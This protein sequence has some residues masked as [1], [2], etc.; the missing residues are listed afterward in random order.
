MNRCDWEDIS[1]LLH[2]NERQR[3]A[4]ET[5][6]RLDVFEMLDR[7]TPT[8]VGTVPIDIDVPES[9]LDIICQADDLQKFAEDVRRAYGNQD[10]FRLWQR[11][12]RDVPSVV[13]GFVSEEFPIEMFAQ[14]QPVT[15]QNAYRHMVVEARLLEIGGPAARKAT[16][17]PSSFPT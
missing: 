9:D 7:Y 13:A 14:P 8:L 16:T 15:A 10:D 3:A 4:Y 17:S 2:G 12:I 1:S 11:R 5:L 6:Q